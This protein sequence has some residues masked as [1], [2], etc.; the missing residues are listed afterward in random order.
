M[1]P[2]MQIDSMMHY[3]LISGSDSDSGSELPG[4]PR[5]PLTSTENLPLSDCPFNLSRLRGRRGSMPFD[6]PGSD[7]GFDSAFLK[8]QAEKR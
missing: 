3:F 2:A 7:F 4:S 1:D 8:D 5:T 6:L